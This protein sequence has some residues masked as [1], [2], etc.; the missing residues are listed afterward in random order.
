VFRNGVLLGSV[1]TGGALASSGGRIGVYTDYGTG[2][3]YT[4]LDD[5]GG[6]DVSSLSS[7]AYLLQ[8]S[9]AV[10]GEGAVQ[11][12][13]T[14]AI[15]CGQPVTITAVAAAGW[16]FGGWTGDVV[17]TQN[18]LTYDLTGSLT[19]VANFI[20]DSAERP[21]NVT[22]QALGDGVVD[23]EPAGPYALGQVVRLTARPAAGWIFT[24]WSGAQPA[25]NNP[26]ALQV[27]DDVALT[28]NF[29]AATSLYLP[30]V[31]QADSV[32]D[33]VGCE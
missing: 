6:G 17:D 25:D 7:S 20:P 4:L 13:P 19:L 29:A 1:N 21:Y 32:I 9:T 24:G 14:G 10:M 5:F 18:P 2:S 15:A 8:V 16:Q 28:G 3:G 27:A 33:A 23:V 22:V 12:E 26:L 30:N 11:V 31:R